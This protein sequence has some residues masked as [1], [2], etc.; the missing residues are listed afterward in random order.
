M[1]LGALRSSER[2]LPGIL[3]Q[4]SQ[5]LADSLT[6]KQNKKLRLCSQGLACLAFLAKVG[7]KGVKG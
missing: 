5:V 2:A 6:E 3:C 1:L 4:T 7:L